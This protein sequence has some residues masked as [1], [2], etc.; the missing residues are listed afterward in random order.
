MSTTSETEK[1]ATKAKAPKPQT[2]EVMAS[3]DQ[4]AESSDTQAEAAKPDTVTKF[5][6]LGLWYINHA[7][8]QDRESIGIALIDV[9]NDLYG[10]C[11]KEILDAKPAKKDGRPHVPTVEEKAQAL[12]NAKIA[13]FRAVQ[14]GVRQW[15]AELTALHAEA[16]GT[17]PE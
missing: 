17:A 9:P 10:D 11:V 7:M 4:T 1:K 14:S 6:E 13:I 8:N 16:E 12:A 3:K 15:E 2:P 5:L